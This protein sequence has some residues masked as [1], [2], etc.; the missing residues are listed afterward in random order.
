MKNGK[1]YKYLL[2]LD[3]SVHAKRAAQYLALRGIRLTKSDVTVIHVLEGA[4]LPD[5]V[6]FDA[7]PTVTSIR[8]QMQAAGLPTSLCV[9]PGTPVAQI[10]ADK[11]HRDGYDEI[12]MGSR[13]AGAIE[14]LTLGSV[15]YKVI[16]LAKVPVTVVPNPG[17][18]TELETKYDGST[19]RILLAVDRSRHAARAVEYVCKLREASVPLE[20]HL[21]NVQRPIAS[22][23]VTRY[24]SRETIEEFLREEGGL[25]ISPAAQ[26]LKQAAI[27]FLPQV[28]MGPVAE[29]IVQEAKKTGC[30]RIV[31]GTRGLGTLAGM[32]LGSSAMKVLHLS[33][34]PV[35]LVK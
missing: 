20:V 7:D 17:D 15:A 26:A 32:A 11:A 30:T 2:A 12:V 21:L 28:R 6:P 25:A 5:T 24:I 16:H 31:M 23:Q 10:I 1:R 13:G 27:P 33:E 3:G 22:G 18:A 14:G 35:T 19:H 9:V 34:L 29:G 4:P 8:L